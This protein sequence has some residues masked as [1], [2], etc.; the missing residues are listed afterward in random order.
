MGADRMPISDIPMLSMHPN[1]MIGR[2]A[3]GLQF[4]AA[5]SD[6]YEVHR[7]GNSVTHE[8][9]SVT[10]RSTRKFRPNITALSPKSS[11][12]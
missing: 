11:V 12:T 9:D 1:H 6:R 4:A 3:R 7:R 5:G 8:D 2:G 10:P